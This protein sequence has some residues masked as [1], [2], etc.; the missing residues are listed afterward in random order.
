MESTN[1]PNHNMCRLIDH[2]VI[3]ATK[4][5]PLAAVEY[6]L[7]SGCSLQDIDRVLKAV[8]PSSACGR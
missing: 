1:R 4:Q 6:L 8:R 7:K 2:V 3:L 5:S